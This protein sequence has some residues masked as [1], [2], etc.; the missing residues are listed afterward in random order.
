MS[1]ALVNSACGC[2]VCS[3]CPI[4]IYPYGSHG[5]D[6]FRD[7]GIAWTYSD[8]SGIESTIYYGWNDPNKVVG[9][10]VITEA[11]GVIFTGTWSASSIYGINFGSASF[12]VYIPATVGLY[13]KSY[14]LI[15]LLP[16][17]FADCGICSAYAPPAC[18]N[19]I[20]EY[21]FIDSTFDIGHVWVT[22]AWQE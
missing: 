1:R 2:P 12:T 21:I 16:D 5:N 18:A 22:Y 4:V 15:D 8:T 17:E 20:G 14:N 13:V 11:N 3:T 9:T 19:Y 7:N 10:K 6:D